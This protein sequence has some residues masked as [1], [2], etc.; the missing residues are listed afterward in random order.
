MVKGS[1]GQD[2]LFENFIVLKY[3]FKLGNL[4]TDVQSVNSTAKCGVIKGCQVCISM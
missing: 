2:F 1:M 3:I 4:G